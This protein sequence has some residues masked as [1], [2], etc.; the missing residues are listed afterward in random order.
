[1]ENINCDNAE[2]KTFINFNGQL[3]KLHIQ[4]KIDL[5]SIVL[6]YR[7]KYRVCWREIYYK[8]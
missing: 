8:L 4:S 1:M 6:K 7:E 5:A 3:K 2:A